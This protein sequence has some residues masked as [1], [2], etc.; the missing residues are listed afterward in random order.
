MDCMH[1]G[2]KDEHAGRTC[3]LSWLAHPWWDD[4]CY[5]VHES[6]SCDMVRH[7]PSSSMF[8]G[9]TQSLPFLSAPF[10]LEHT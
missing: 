1:T 10:P 7:A 8:L 2:I 9:S 3:L 5:V 6:H 4:I